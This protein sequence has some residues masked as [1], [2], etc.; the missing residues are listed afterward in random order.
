MRVLIVSHTYISPINRRKW[1]V[2]ASLFSEVNI[3]VIFPLV[4]PTTIF[5]H[6]AEADLTQFNSVNCNFIALKVFKAGNEVLYSYHPAKLLNLIKKTRP[7]IIHVEQGDNALS[8]FQIIL[9]SKILRLKSRFIFFTWVNWRHK[10]SLKYRIFWKRIEIF[11]L[12]KSD[13]AIAGNS[14]AKEILFEKGFTK[15][16]ITLPQ[17]G[18]DTQIFQPAQKEKCDII[19]IGFAGRLVE[20]KGIFL[21]LQAF[22]ALSKKYPNLGLSYLG[23]GP[24]GQEL[25]YQIKKN[26]LLDKIE[27]IMPVPHELVAKFMQSLDIFVLPS[28]DT[29]VWREQ[30]GHVLIEAMACKVAVIGSDAGEISNVL[31]D[32]GLIFKQNDVLALRSVLELLVKDEM[33]RANIAKMGYEKTLRQYSCEAIAKQTHNFWNSILKKGECCE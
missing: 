4:W 24:C 10:F 18:V 5:N 33:L 27:V 23:V 1:Q 13:A 30:F 32:A 9:F 17:L 26:N 31:S 16:V 14:T 2:L 29:P 11:N 19:R 6:K 20:E 28:F 12:K 8:Y 22:T 3:T 21:L 25:D 15:P 7:D